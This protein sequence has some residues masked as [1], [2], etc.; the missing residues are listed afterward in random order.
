MKIFL[1]FFIGLAANLAV[2]IPE[3]C[4]TSQKLSQSDYKDWK[5]VNTD[6]FQF[7]T[8]SNMVDEKA[9]GVDS[10]FWKFSNKEMILNIE[11]G[12]YNPKF[13]DW[14]TRFETESNYEDEKVNI[15]GRV[16]FFYTFASNKNKADE[17]KSAPDFKD[18][19][20]LAGIYFEG[21]EN[22]P[23]K[24]SFIVAGN[25]K[26]T[27]ETARK[28]FQSIKFTNWRKHPQKYGD[29]S[30]VCLFD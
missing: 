3:G 28:M 24:L 5:Q 27:Q 12:P 2:F 19:I 15:D 9:R 14:K 13:E 20:F 21:V 17:E 10:V 30:K 22:M 29:C 6:Y 26:Q 18:K 11:L 1:V 7:Q 16:G 8:P 4:S 23:S 25:S